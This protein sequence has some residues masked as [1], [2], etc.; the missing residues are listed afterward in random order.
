MALF[1]IIKNFIH[2]ETLEKMLLTSEMSPKE[3]VD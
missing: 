1:K 3:L 2:P